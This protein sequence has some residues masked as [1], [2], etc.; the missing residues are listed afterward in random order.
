MDR[1]YRL[2]NLIDEVR[3]AVTQELSA[4]VA[5]LRLEQG[6]RRLLA[7]PFFL[8]EE[9]ERVGTV[10]DE[11]CL[12]RDPDLD[13]VVLARGVGSRRGR[14]G[15]SHAVVPHDHG[16]LWALYGVYEGTTNLQRYEPDDSE[17]S[18]RF[19]GLRLVKEAPAK[20]GDLDAITPHHMHLPL[21]APDATSTIV[22]VYNKPL[23]SVVR[24][25]YVPDLQSVVEF[26]GVRPPVRSTSKLIRAT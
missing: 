1:L 8:K 7:N 17:S 21:N 19:P 4:D 16:P 12:Y 26:Q 14:K 25:G 24:R 6:F 11:T 18:G 10:R 22:V 15:T 23:E 5:L 13:F 3:D 9:L 2:A 20:A